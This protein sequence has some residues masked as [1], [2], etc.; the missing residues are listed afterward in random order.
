M[1]WYGGC[2]E[3][4]FGIEA[5]QN[6][7]LKLV[8]KGLKV[9]DHYA[10]VSLAKKIGFRT[11]IFIMTG[12]P[13]ETKDSADFMIDF[14]DDV[15]PDVVTLTTFM[16]IPGSDV[17]HNPEL[18]NGIILKHDYTDYDFS[19]KYEK[20]QP[21]GFL[22]NGMTLEDMEANREKLKGYIFSQGISNVFKYNGEYQ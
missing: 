1:L 17:Y 5:A 4:G 15:K 3:I 13:G 6:S 7:I 20:G 11:R 16:P 12:L 19:L 14:L 21:F 9:E 2:R 18:Y 22:P 10:G 8:S